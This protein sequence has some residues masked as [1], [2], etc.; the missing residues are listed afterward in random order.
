MA[1]TISFHAGTAGT[2]ANLAGSGLGFFGASFGQSV[3]VGSYQ[4]T[5]YI[6]NST[7][8]VEGNVCENTKYIHPAS[9]NQSD[10]GE[11]NLQ[12]IPNRLA[13]LNI[14]FS[15]DT[16]VKTQ[17]AKLRIFDRSNINNEASG[18]TTKVAELIHPHPNQAVVSNSSDATWSTPAGSAVIMD[19]LASPGE[20]GL[21]PAGPETT[22]DRHDWYVVISASPDSIG[23]KTLYGL[24][25]EL[26]Y[27]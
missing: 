21:S 12:Y 8:S 3:E 9:G 7:G 11:I 6:T 27:L 25:V 13:T 2:I 19:L 26:E 10:A 5:T 4:D 14:R 18:V 17:N 22:D 23:A 24:Y 15:N 20:S 16:A 1:A